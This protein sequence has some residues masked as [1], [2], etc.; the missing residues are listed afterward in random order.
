MGIFKNIY[1]YLPPITEKM[2]LINV[3]IVVLLV[4]VVIQLT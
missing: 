2:K 1:L 4:S 3:I